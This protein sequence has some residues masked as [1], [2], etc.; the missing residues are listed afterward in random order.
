MEVRDPVCG[1]QFAEQQGAGQTVYGGR[2]F[3]FCS[4]YCKS[5]F[6]RDPARY[7]EDKPA[8]WETR[9]AGPYWWRPT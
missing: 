6:E 7:V 8:H 5:V 3:H 1:M 9:C 2:V 4:P